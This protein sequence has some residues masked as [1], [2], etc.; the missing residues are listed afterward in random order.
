MKDSKPRLDRPA[1]L[2]HGVGL[3]R[4]H[5]ERVLSG[6]T[7][8]DWFEVISENFMVD[9]G[10]PLDVLR[11]VRERYPVVLHGVSLSIGSTDPLDEAYLDRLDDLARRFEPAWVSDHLCWTS[12]G[13]HQA[14]DL[15]P[16]P[17]TEEALEN[18]VARVLRVQERLRRPIALENV[19]SYVAY[20]AS[21]MPEWEFLARVAERSG[22]G[23]LL[24]INNIYVSA[25]NHDFDARAYLAGIPPAKV[26]QF[27]LAGHSDKGDYLL[28][29][30]DHPVADPVWDL[31]RDAVRRFGAVSTLIEWDDKIPGFD[32]LEAE[33]ERARAI[34][35]EVLVAAERPAA[36]AAAPGRAAQAGAI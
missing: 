14:H 13:G 2:G 35:R 34:R 1:G 21:A 6:P 23:I 32:R 24:D 7:R 20:R 12:V 4:D 27:H 18:V 19:S 10:R 11:R 15:L 22:C 36:G 5:F 17:Y 29:T 8:I 3:R 16:L 30:H 9:G 26:W 33:S 28:D 25:R 31:Y